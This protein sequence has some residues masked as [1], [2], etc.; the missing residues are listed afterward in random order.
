MIVFVTGMARSGTS[1]VAGLLESMGCSTI[2]NGPARIVGKWNPDYHENSIINALAE[3]IHPWHHIEPKKPSSTWIDAIACY[4]LERN[5]PYPL[6]LKS[7]TFP[8]IIPELV[9]LAK[10]ME[11]VPRFVV[12]TRDKKA[13][14]HSCNKFT[15]RRIPIDHWERLYDVV[16]RKL[17]DELP[18]AFH[19][20]YET[21]LE[22]WLMTSRALAEYI[23]G[24]TVPED[25]G[26]RN[27]L[28][29]E[30]APA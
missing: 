16:M 19:I 8:F 14:T 26:I 28:N 11:A 15:G 24:L 4:I 1:A 29:H 22:Q 25:G 7:P 21:L 30:G 20:E 2:N 17:D 23:P 9:R 3:A 12:V 13:V 18:L 5:P 6:V 10:Q 27:E